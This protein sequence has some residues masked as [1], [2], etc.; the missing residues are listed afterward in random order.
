MKMATIGSVTAQSVASI[1]G[2]AG[3]FTTGGGVTTA[4]GVIKLANN[5]ATLQTN[6]A[7]PRALR[8]RSV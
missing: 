1:D 5:S 8:V 4:A 2:N 7:I 6:P 3:A